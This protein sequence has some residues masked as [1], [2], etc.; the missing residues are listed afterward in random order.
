MGKRF[1]PRL[2]LLSFAAGT[3]IH[4]VYAGIRRELTIERCRQFYLAIRAMERSELTVPLLVHRPSTMPV[5]IVHT[6]L[7]VAF[8]AVWLV[9]GQ[10]MVACR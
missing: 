2:F 1:V 6:A 9:V 7:G 5:E 3:S 10:I 4:S 8:T